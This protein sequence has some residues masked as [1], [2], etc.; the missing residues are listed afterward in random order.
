[1]R[2][3]DD[4]AQR[5]PAVVRAADVLLAVQRDAAAVRPR[6]G[7]VSLRAY[8]RRRYPRVR[9]MH[10]H[11]DDLRLASWRSA[12]FL[13]P[14][15]LAR[16]RLLR[17]RRRPGQ[18]RRRGRRHVD[19]EGRRSTTGSTSPPKS[20]G[21]GGDGGA[22]AAGLRGVRRAR[23]RKTTAEAGQGPAEG[24]PTRSSRPSASRSTSA[25]RPGDAAADLVPVD[26]GRGEGAGRQGHRRRGQEDRSTSRRSRRS[27]RTPTTRS[28]SRTR[29]RPRRT[30]SARPARHA[31]EQDPRQGRPRARTRSPTPQIQDYYN[32]NKA[33]FAQPERRDLRIVLTKS[34]AKAE[35]GQGGARER[36]AFAKVAKKYSIDEASKA[37][38]GK[39]PAV[40]KG[41]QEKALDD[42]D[43]QG[44][45]GQADRA[46]Q[47]PVRLLRLR[48]HEGHHGRRSRRSTQAKATIKQ[49]LASQN[50]QKALDTFVKDFRKRWKDEDGLPRGLR[51]A[52][53]QER[54]EGDADA[55]APRAPQ[56]APR[57][58][59]SPA[60]APDG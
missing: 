11:R 42:G 46:G 20:S 37:Q 1:M 33:R 43:L 4:P 54:A 27:R 2:V 59:R 25:A 15:A 39:L 9:A 18:R 6:S 28:S 23:K 57:A 45:E 52:G 60:A 17:G 44:Q 13:C 53:L 30:S 22:Q 55:R 21:Q 12:P 26:R 5:F 10:E 34:K 51:D 40:A 35:R 24:R 58:A 31:L 32:K 47:D 41:Q 19:R 7:Y 56:Q 49:M 29:A 38:G 3:P 50:Q 8:H 36:P 48:G 14:A 16:R